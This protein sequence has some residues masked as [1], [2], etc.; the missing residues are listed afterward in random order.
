MYNK[1]LHTLPTGVLCHALPQVLQPVLGAPMAWETWRVGP[2]LPSQC[3]P[4]TKYGSFN[5]RRIAVPCEPTQQGGRP[6]GAAGGGDGQGMGVGVAAAAAAQE[7]GGE[8]LAGRGPVGTLAGGGALSGQ[9]GQQV[10]HT[11]RSSGTIVASGDGAEEGSS[12]GGRHTGAG[13]GGNPACPGWDSLRDHSKWGISVQ[14]P[15][16]P[17]GDRQSVSGLGSEFSAGETAAAAAAATAVTGKRAGVGAG[18][19][20]PA[21]GRAGVGL[22]LSNG[23]F[24]CIGDLNRQASQ[25]VRGGGF[26]CSGDVG[27]WRAF[28]SLV[29]EVEPCAPTEG[30][31]E[32]GR[33]KEQGEA[34]VS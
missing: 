25:R 16:A 17:E 18:L 8:G 27:L 4:A 1:P 29:Y 12:G 15:A 32:E 31:G 7:G 34:A 11:N 19:I 26:V 30:Q 14:Q 23:P 24:T 22:G 10:T 13:S 5:V 20:A 21:T 6:G 28:Q 2:Y 3:P 9:A 33:E